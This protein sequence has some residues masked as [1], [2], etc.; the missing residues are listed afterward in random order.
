MPTDAGKGEH[1]YYLIKRPAENPNDTAEIEARKHYLGIDAVR[2][3]VNKQG[4]ILTNRIASGTVH[5]SLANETY[6]AGL[7]LYQL[8][9]GARTAPIFDRPVL[10][11][12]IYP[13]DKITLRIYMR[14]IQQDTLL[15]GLLRE[16]S[17]ASL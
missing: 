9:G 14:A 11:N 5:V 13:G 12:R 2:W 15:G 16:M 17:K 8:E 10:P 4:T 3:F 7:G 6:D 1:H